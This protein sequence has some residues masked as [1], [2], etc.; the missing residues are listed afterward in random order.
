MPFTR[1]DFDNAIRELGQCEDDV[2]RRSLLV[3]L[4]DNVSPVF[5]ENQNLTQTNADLTKDLKEAQEHNMELFLRVGEKRET[6][7]PETKEEKREPRKFSDLFDEKGN[8]K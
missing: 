3:Q 7:T 6:E 2:T 4:S 5:D 1:E 8:I